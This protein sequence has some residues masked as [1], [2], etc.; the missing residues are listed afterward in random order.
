MRPGFGPIGGP[1]LRRIRSYSTWTS[2]NEILAEGSAEVEKLLIPIV[3]SVAALTPYTLICTVAAAIFLAIEPITDT[4]FPLS[5]AYDARNDRARL[6]ELLIRGTKLVMGISLPLAVAVAAYGEAFIVAWIGEQHVAVPHGVLPLIVVSF[7]VTAFIMTG[8]TVLLALAKVREVF[9]MGIAELALAVALVL[10]TVPRFGLPGLAASLMIANVLVT[11]GWIV[12]SVTRLLDQ[13]RTDFL[14]QSLLRPLL[15][16]LPMALFILW[17]DQHLTGATLPWLVL[18]SGLAGCVYLA[19]FYLV[20]LTA[21]ERV[22]CTGSV[23]SL[24]GSK[25]E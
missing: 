18:K 5:S 20:S 8:T 24:L 15:A 16:A 17:M 4:F 12:P 21:D 7:A 1:H 22:L 11:F 10:V 2:L 13:P 23:R 9:W 25:P 6:R 3:L 14:Y 19:A